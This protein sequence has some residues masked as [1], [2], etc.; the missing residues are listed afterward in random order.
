MVRKGTTATRA[1]VS[2]RV[3]MVRIVSSFIDETGEMGTIPTG[4]VGYRCRKLP[5]EAKGS[6]LR[7]QSRT[8]LVA[9]QS[10]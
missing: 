3:R 7:V 5:G 6:A 4:K 2:A 8:L 1:R 9:Q 10:G